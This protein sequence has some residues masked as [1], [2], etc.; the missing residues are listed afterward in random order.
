MMMMMMT[1]L[2]GKNQAKMTK[3]VVTKHSFSQSR[4]ITTRTSSTTLLRLRDQLLHSFR[5]IQSLPA[6]FTMFRDE[7]ASVPY[8]VMHTAGGFYQVWGNDENGNYGVKTYSVTQ[9]ND[10][11]VFINEW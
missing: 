3:S 4:S 6:G 11:S 9:P 5:L 7:M 8:S 10:T 1:N 2:H